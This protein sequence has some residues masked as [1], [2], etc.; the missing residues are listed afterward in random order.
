MDYTYVIQSQT[1]RSNRYIG[2]TSDLRQRLTDHHD[3]KCSHTAR[4]RPW[5]LRLY[6][7]FESIDLARRFEQY[8]KSGS[9]HAFAHRHFGF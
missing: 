7:A 5:A 4:S 8:L 6:V 1:D 9:G 2:H 3:G